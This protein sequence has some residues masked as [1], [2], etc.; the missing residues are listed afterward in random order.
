MIA[1]EGSFL[2]QNE[3][4]KKYGM[5][6]NLKQIQYMKVTKNKEVA[7]KHMNLELKSKNIV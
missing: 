6:V 7:R 2:V 5:N 3:A 4:A 1:A